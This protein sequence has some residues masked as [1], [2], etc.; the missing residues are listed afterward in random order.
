MQHKDTAWATVADMIQLHC[1]Y[2]TINT[3]NQTETLKAT[4]ISER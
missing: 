2:M 4:T 3:S 1:L